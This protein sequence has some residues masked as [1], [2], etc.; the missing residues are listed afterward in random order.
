MGIDIAKE[1]AQLR[2]MKKNQQ[3]AFYHQEF[4]DRYNVIVSAL[5]AKSLGVEAFLV[6]T[7]D[8]K[9]VVLS[10]WHA[11]RGTPSRPRMSEPRLQ[12]SLFNERLDGLL[13]YLEKLS[14]SIQPKLADEMMVLAR[15]GERFSVFVR[16]LC[17]RQRGRTPLNVEDE[18][19]VQDLLHALLRLHFE[20]VRHEDV[21]P[22]YANKSSRMDFFLPELGI[23]VEAKF[24]HDSEHAKEIGTEIND[25]TARYDARPDCNQLVVLIYDPRLRVD[26]PVGV[27]KDLETRTVKGNNISV[28]IC[29]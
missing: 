2:A 20:D 14:A 27:K 15:I 13:E 23:A 3:Y 16:Q 26:N 6:T 9:P 18:Y 19:D 1:T 29:N 11:N 17:K 22:K 5:L 24:V 21:T 28:Y 10:S 25:D 8:I 4:A 7:S 12:G